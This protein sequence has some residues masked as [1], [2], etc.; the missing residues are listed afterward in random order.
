M[1]ANPLRDFRVARAQTQSLGFLRNYELADQALEET[2]VSAKL[3]QVHAAA[4]HLRVVFPDAG[5][6]G[7]GDGVGANLRN[8]F[9]VTT[10]I[11]SAGVASRS[12]ED[13][14]ADRHQDCKSENDNVAGSFEAA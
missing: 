7:D 10:R 2:L 11:E 12:V 8:N 3:G 5:E 6:I 1:L 13:D 9:R 4:K 14:Q